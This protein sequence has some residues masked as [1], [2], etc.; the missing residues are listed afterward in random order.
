M[1][2]PLP[3]PPLEKVEYQALVKSAKS[4]GKSKV[5]LPN[6]QNHP[7]GPVPMV[8]REELREAHGVYYPDKR[9]S[10]TML[11]Q[12]FP[13]IDFSGLTSDDDDLWHPEQRESLS[14]VNRRITS[15]FEW[16]ATRPE[17]TIAVVTHG[18]WMEECLRRY[19]PGVL[20][21]GHRVL[22]GEVYRCSV[23]ASTR[24][25]KDGDEIIGPL[26]VKKC[27]VFTELSHAGD[28]ERGVRL[29]ALQRD[30]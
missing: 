21:G 7:A 24:E 23:Q 26:M 8:C 22:N 25:N 5:K 29:S 17:S 30:M 11:S 28:N 20:K 13:N 4:E 18:V 15:F 2:A 10:R 19:T 3:P 9:R 6:P 27:D 16:L 1:G 12:G 14:D